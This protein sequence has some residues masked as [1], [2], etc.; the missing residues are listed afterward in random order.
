MDTPSPSPQP[1]PVEAQVVEDRREPQQPVVIVQSRRNGWSRFVS[2]LGWLGL[3]VCLPVLVGMVV[4]YRDYY[5]T[6][7]GI[8]EKFHSGN[9]HGDQKI[10][11]IEVSGLITDGEGFVKN[12]IDRVR[13]DQQVKAV[14]VR[15][16]SPGGTITGSDFVYHHLRRLREER[17]LPLVV[18]M[19][20][21]A[22]SGGYYVAMAVGDTPDSIFAEPTT[23]TG[24]IGVI[25]PHYNLS[26]LLERWDIQDDSLSTDPRKELLSMTK[27][28]SDDQRQILL[29]YLNQAFDRFKEIVQSGR[30]NLRDDPQALRNVTTGEFF[31]SPTALELGLVDKLGFVEEAIRRAAE[32]A[33]IDPEKTRVVR[34][35]APL[36]F[37][38]ALGGRAQQPRRSGLSELLDGVTPRA[39]YLW[40]LIPPLLSSPR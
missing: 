17:E 29:R 22:A 9:Q 15:I 39:Y 26:G 10:A 32:L 40:T 21:V 34:Y 1:T 30:P 37:M 20:G 16:N 14:V 33:G 35:E 24:S 6:T 23:T 38:T 36:T 3:L 18:S 8:R 19:G 31:S 4:A 13:A 28:M 2:W 5:D 27:P 12:Q 25:I 7:D 11:I